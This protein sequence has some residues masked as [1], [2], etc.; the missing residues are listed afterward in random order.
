MKQQTS[1][2]TNNY[3]T[4]IGL[5]YIL[6]QLCAHSTVKKHAVPPT[7]EVCD[8]LPFYIVHVCGVCACVC[9]TM[10]NLKG[11]AQSWEFIGLLTDLLIKLDGLFSVQTH[12]QEIGSYIYCP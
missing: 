11:L 12:N 2:S 8:A 4:L 10:C 7:A 1:R 3:Q 5:D 6:Q 9:V